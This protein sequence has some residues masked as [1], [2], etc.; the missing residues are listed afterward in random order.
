MKAKVKNKIRKT[1]KYTIIIISIIFL[2]FSL[3]VFLKCIQQENMITAT[4]QI[5]SY[6]N[7]FN[8]DYKVN[9]ISNKYMT[10]SEI[11]DKSLAYVTDLID[12]I[13]LNLNYEYKA[14]KNSDMNYTYSIIGKMQAF[15][16]K[17][18]EEQKIWEKEE[19][20]LPEKKL[21]SSVNHFN[22]NEDLTLDLKDKNDLINNFKQQLGMTIDAKYTIS[23]AIKV[24]TEIEGKEIVD[25]VTPSIVIDLAEKT[26]KIIGENNLENTKYISEE[27]AL[28]EKASQFR[29]FVDVVFMI[30]AI[31][32]LARV[33][34][35][36]NANVVRNEYKYE[37]NRI[38][39]I[40]HDKIVQV[41]TK[42]NDEEIE[43]VYVKDFGEIFKVSEE[44]FKPI[45]YFNA[46]ENEEAWFSVMSGKTSYRFILKK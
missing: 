39:R 8:Y 37:L 38:L 1:T 6:T 20:L 27:V 15:Y 32:V 33:S 35:F 3:N 22:I 45:L 12:N 28:S 7:K 14:D 46:K 10:N 34:R 41:S 5:Y 25:E 4:K 2:I 26:T 43:V 29:I 9:L 23:L 40:C 44:L 36:R 13:G 19:V 11:E 42:P 18:G 30:I 17:N 24:V 16:T 31:V 21:S